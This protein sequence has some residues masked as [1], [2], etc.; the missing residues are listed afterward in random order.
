[1]P[2]SDESRMGVV[3][4]IADVLA[5]PYNLLAGLI[6]G[7]VAP[8]A[9]I[10]AMAAMVLCVRQDCQGGNE[11]QPSFPDHPIHYKE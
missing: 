7:F 3:G 8:I 1:M 10:A 4:A 2:S 6:L 5:I 11:E 9:A